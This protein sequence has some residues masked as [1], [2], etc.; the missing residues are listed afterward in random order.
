M[1]FTLKIGSLEQAQT[2]AIALFVWEEGFTPYADQ[3]DRVL[4]GFLKKETLRRQFKAE[5]GKFL[6]VP[7]YKKL[8]AEKV[9][10]LGLG[11]KADFNALKARQVFAALA[12][13]LKE[14]GIESLGFANQADF[15]FVQ[16]LVEGITLGSYQFGK[17]KSVGPSKEKETEKEI[18][19]LVK[20]ARELVSLREKLTRGEILSQATIFARDLVN[21]PSSVTTPTYLASLAEKIGKNSKFLCKIYEKE[22]LKKLGMG[23]LLG[24]AQG[25][26]EPPKLIRLEYNPPSPRLRRARKIVL[27]GKGITFDTGGLSLKKQNEMETMKMDM[28]GAA[29]ILAVFSVLEKIKPRVHIIGLMPVTENMPS[30]KAIKPGD[31]VKAYNGK[32]IEVVNTDAEGR[33]ILA[34][35]LAFGETLKPDLILDIA[36][37]TGACLVALGEDIAGIFSDEQKLVKEISQAGEAVGEKFWPMPLEKT[38]RE[39]LKSETADLKNVTGRHVGG[40]ITAALF[41]QEFISKTPW[42]HLDIAGPAWQEKGTDLLPRG[43]TGF[44]VRTILNFLEA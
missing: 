6:I 19:I 7:S 5:T 22:D 30:G 37:L 31:I 28:A 27:V 20:D 33:L 32:T 25:S 2:E 42:A 43:G 14:E 24:V 26:D 35:A 15:E 39:L 40:A 21:E 38:Y 3:I 13:K 23:A 4:G 1:K 12:K 29:A 18:V 44:A 41:L 34:D 8:F 17:Y 36:T 10:L 9:I 11:K 16:A